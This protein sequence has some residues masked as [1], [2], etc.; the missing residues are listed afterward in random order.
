MRPKTMAGKV[1]AHAGE[2]RAPNSKLQEVSYNQA[3]LKCFFTVRNC[4]SMSWLL[5]FRSAMER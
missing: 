2:I 3:K 4:L 5:D 1:C